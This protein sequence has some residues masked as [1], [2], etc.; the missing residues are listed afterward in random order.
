MKVLITGGNGFI[1]SHLVKYFLTK[2]H[3]VLNIDKISKFSQKTQISS[4]KYLFKKINLLNTR[5]LKKIFY[6]FKPSLIIHSAAE[7]HVDRSIKNPSS[8]FLNNILSTLNLLDLTKNKKIKFIHIS[9]DEVFGSLKKNEE[10]FNSKSSY[11]PRNPYSASKAASDHAVRSYG[12]TFNLNYKIINCSN[13][14]GPFQHYEKLIPKVILN[15]LNRKKIPIYGNGSNIRDWIFVEDHVRAIY[16]I[17][18]LRTKRKT[19]LIGGNNQISNL[20]LVKIICKKIDKVCK[21]K[22]S[23]SLVKFIKDRPGHDFRYEIDNNDTKKEIN[24]FPEKNLNDGIEETV[25]F[26]IKNYKKLN[27]IFI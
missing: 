11:N 4:R 12:E 22:N 14:Y 16:K 23:F 10:K 24:W 9:T 5:K 25:N 20:S 7:S 21:T 15:C 3:H 17:A 2:K 1:G 8:F 26:Y 13:N 6:T 27:K 18:T 19:F